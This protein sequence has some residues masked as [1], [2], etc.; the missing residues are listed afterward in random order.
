MAGQKKRSFGRPNYFWPTKKIGQKLAVNS[1]T[2][3]LK[4]P[5]NGLKMPENDF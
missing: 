4:M 2:I 3:S 5:E 1:P